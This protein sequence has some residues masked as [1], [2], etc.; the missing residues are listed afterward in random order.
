MV[1]SNE[2]VKSYAFQKQ[3][4]IA[5]SINI[6]KKI[7]TKNSAEN[8]SISAPKPQSIKKII[9]E[10]SV[11]KIPD[12][13]SL[14]STVTSKKIVY[15]KKTVPKKNILN[16]RRVAQMQKRIKKSEARKSSDARRKIENLKLTK[17][18]VKEVGLSSSGG[19]EVNKYY[20][21]IQAFV[22]ERFYPPVNSEGTSAKV[23]I[24]LSANGRLSDYRVMAYSK[25]NMF[26]SEVDQ[27]KKR[28]SS[29]TFPKHPKGKSLVLDIILVSEE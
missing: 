16:E 14:F 26:N 25:S 20:A 12:I 28:L 29:I 22:Y 4:Y 5:V 7:P 11:K 15:K 10:D 17:P 9:P 21:K 3:K 13:S 18:S 8:A 2:K 6:S 27:L 1:L 23:R 24:W 19:V